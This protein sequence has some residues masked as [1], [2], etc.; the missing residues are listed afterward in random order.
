MKYVMIVDGSTKCWIETDSDSVAVRQL[1]FENGCLKSSC[2]IDCL[3]EGVINIDDMSGN[4][5][6]ISADTFETEWEK[7]V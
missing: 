4:I 7:L 6:Y 2:K 5:D 3:A 1:I